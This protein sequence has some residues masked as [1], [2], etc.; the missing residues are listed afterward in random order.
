M[1][2]LAIQVVNYNTKSYLIRCLDDI[3]RDLKGATFSYRILVLD[4]H[5]NDDLS[6]LAPRY[7]GRVEFY[8]AASNGGFGAG[9]NFLA[10]QDASRYILILNPDIEFPAP[11]T[12]TP[13]PHLV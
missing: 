9:H 7:G 10:R 13:H 1:V 11:R 6:D 4:N 3:L 12:Q 2:D 8:R 5:S